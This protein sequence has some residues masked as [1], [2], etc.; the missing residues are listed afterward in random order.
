MNRIFWHLFFYSQFLQGRLYCSIFCRFSKLNDQACSSKFLFCKHS[1]KIDQHYFFLR[2][3][4]LQRNLKESFLRLYFFLK[5][6]LEFFSICMKEHKVLN[7]I[8]SLGVQNW[9]V[10]NDD[11]CRY[12]FPAVKTF[13]LSCGWSF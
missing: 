13:F 6:Y 8:F 3:N 7:C 12:V 10:S 5:F 9:I 4:N 11:K 1:H 2:L